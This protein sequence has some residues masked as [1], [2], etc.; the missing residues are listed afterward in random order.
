MMSRYK[1]L[2]SILIGE[3]EKLLILDKIT[4]FIYLD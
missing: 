1:Y 4:E 2:E 3:R